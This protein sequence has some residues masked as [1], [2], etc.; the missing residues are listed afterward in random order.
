VAPDL[1]VKGVYFN[2]GGTPEAELES[3]ASHHSP[4]FRIQPEP[5]VKAGVEAMVVGAMTLMPK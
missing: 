5:S 2:V 3:A 4:Y 1:G